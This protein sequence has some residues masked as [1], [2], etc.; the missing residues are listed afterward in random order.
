MKQIEKKAEEKL[1]A[2]EKKDQEGQQMLKYLEKLQ[3]EDLEWANNFD[4]IFK[5]DSGSN[6]VKACHKNLIQCPC[7]GAYLG[8]GHWAMAP[9]F[10][11]PGS[12]NC[13]E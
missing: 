2:L 8:G 11:S 1:Q 10:G 5:K 7:P 6:S 4:A 9:L 12:Y 3:R 13:I